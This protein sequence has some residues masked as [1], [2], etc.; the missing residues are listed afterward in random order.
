M[1]S[2][3]IISLAASLIKRPGVILQYYQHNTWDHSQPQKAFF[4]LKSCMMH[5]LG[6][7]SVF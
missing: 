1:S 5:V 6:V 3:V 2:A 4:T 7:K